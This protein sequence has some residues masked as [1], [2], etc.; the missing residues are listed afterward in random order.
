MVAVASLLSQA[1]MMIYGFWCLKDGEQIFGFS[2]RSIL[3]K[4]NITWPMIRLAIPIMAEKMAFSLGKVL[5]NAM[6]VVF[7][8]SIVGALGISNNIGGITTSPPNGIQEGGASI[9]SQNLGNH[10]LDRALDAFKKILIINVVIGLTGFTLTSIFMTPIINLFAQGD[11]H[12]AEE[13]RSI[14]GYERWGGLLLSITASVM[15]L[16]YGFGYT[17]ISLMINFARVFIF[18]VPILYILSKYTTLGSRSVGYSM[19]LS[20]ALIGITSGIIGYFVIRKIKKRYKKIE[21]ISDY[22]E[23]I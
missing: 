6:S 14:Y 19:M 1:I 5:V 15:A 9:I 13:I 18:R 21:K 4:K 22:V 17:K 7:G 11:I 8:S 23:N 2:I 20:N 3:L 12:F 10:N 16:L